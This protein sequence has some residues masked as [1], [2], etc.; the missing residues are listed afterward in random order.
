MPATELPPKPALVRVQTLLD[1][2]IRRART[3]AETA[4][5]LRMQADAESALARLASALGD[6][7]E[8]PLRAAVEGFSV[9]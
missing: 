9:G 2:L 7:D 5:Q 4:D 8:R 6:L 3:G 1:L